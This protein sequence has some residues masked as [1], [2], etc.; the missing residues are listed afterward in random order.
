MT[1]PSTPA[2]RAAGAFIAL[3]LIIGPL[4]GIAFGQPTLGLLAGLGVGLVIA[5]GQW[6]FDRAR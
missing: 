6:L 2:P 4:V 1:K 3:G 5:I